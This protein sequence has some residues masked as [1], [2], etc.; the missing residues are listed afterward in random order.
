MLEEIRDFAQQILDKVSGKTGIKIKEGSTQEEV[1][2]Q[3]DALP[4]FTEM[5]SAITELQTQFKDF[6]P[7]VSSEAVAELI[8]ANTETVTAAYKADLKTAQDNLALEI[9]KT[10]SLILTA[11][12]VHADT[13]P[14]TETPSNTTRQPDEEEMVEVKSFV[15]G[16]GNISAMVAK[17]KVVAVK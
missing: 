1:I 10:K 4:N 8:K 7:G 17:S 5:Q 14:P 11:N 9:G 15:P 16:L 12:K 6:V 2:A 13:A 3:L